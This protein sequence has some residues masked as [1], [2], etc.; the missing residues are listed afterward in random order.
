MSNL[1][2]KGALTELKLQKSAL[3]ISIQAKIRAIK[4]L[5]A[6]SAITAIESIDLASVKVHSDEALALKREYVEITAK[7][8]QIESELC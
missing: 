4:S 6:T 1:E 5:L 3:A 7:I 2:L 8:K